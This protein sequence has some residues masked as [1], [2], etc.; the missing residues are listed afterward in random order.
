LTCLTGA[1][2]A[3]TLQR[4]AASVDFGG[5]AAATHR[6][7]AAN[8]GAPGVVASLSVPAAI[9]LLAPITEIRIGIPCECDVTIE[10]ADE[11]GAPLFLAQAHMPAGWQKVGFSGRDVQGNMLANGVYYYTVTADGYSQT[12][13]VTINR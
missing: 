13:R 12:S 1:S 6:P 4:I 5:V 7:S 10:V 9:E 11:S 8:A 2:E 3:F